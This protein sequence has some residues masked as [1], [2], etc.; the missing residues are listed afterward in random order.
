MKKRWI[1][2]EGVIEIHKHPDEWL[3]DFIDWLE[4]RGESFCGMTSKEFDPEEDNE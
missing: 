3:N 4:S 2:I 1:D